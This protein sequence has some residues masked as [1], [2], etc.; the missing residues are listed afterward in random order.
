MQTSL[1]QSVLSLN[2]NSTD[3]FYWF[4][5]FFSAS[6]SYCTRY[7][8]HHFS[9]SLK[10]TLFCQTF[11][12]LLCSKLSL[13]TFFIKAFP[14]QFQ[15]QRNLLLRSFHPGV[16]LWWVT[17]QF[18]VCF[19]GY[20]PSESSI[21]QL[22]VPHKYFFAAALMMVTWSQNCCLGIIN[23]VSC[24]TSHLYRV[25]LYFMTLLRMYKKKDVTRG[26]RC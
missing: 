1:N 21:V 11:I 2:L 16:P 13:Q 20:A 26:V 9:P 10:K 8:W 15:G 7:A 12:F 4:S 18:I 23:H 3:Y 5:V 25:I 24:S 22:T 14:S 17:S 19:S 6:A